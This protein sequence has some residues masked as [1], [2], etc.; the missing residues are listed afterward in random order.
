M[1]G[2]ESG[3]SAS[4][5]P[6]RQESDPFE[7][8]ARSLEAL[9]AGARAV[10]AQHDG[11]PAVL[12]PAHLEKTAGTLLK[13]EWDTNPATAA[14]HLATL[15]MES[16]TDHLLSMALLLRSTT[17]GIFATYTVS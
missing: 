8:M 11:N 9:A 16:S 6:M 1:G 10:D 4:L 3:G 12:S 2:D 7:V 17:N 14:R 15:L 13:D 5:K